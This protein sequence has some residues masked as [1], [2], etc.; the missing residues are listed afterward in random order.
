MPIRLRLVVLFTLAAALAFALG[1]WLF[2]EQLQRGLLGSLDASIAAQWT[3]AAQGLG[4]AHG[5]ENFQD[6]GGRPAG[7]SSSAPTSIIPPATEYVVQLL[8]PSG[9]V[10]ESN[11][12]AGTAPLLDRAQLHSATQR[13]LVTSVRGPEGDPFRLLAAPTAPGARQVVVVGASLDTVNQ[14][15]V[16]VRRD[17]LIGG[18]VILLASLLGAF[19]LATA[20]LLPVERLRRQVEDLS[21]MDK[22]VSV[23]VPNTKDEIA[24]LARTMNALLARLHHALVRQRSFVSDAGHELRTPFAILQ[25]ELELAGRSGR[26][27]EELVEAV[28]SAAEETARLTRLAEDLLFLARS[29][30]E[31]APLQITRTSLRSIL[32]R[33]AELVESRSENAGVR[34]LVEASDD[35]EADVDAGRI[36]QALDNLLDN[37]LRYA[38]RGSEIVVNAARTNGARSGRAR[39]EVGDRGPGFPSSFLPH[40]FE[41]FR[42]PD[43]GRARGDGGSGLGLA[44]VAAIAEGHGGSASVANREGG[45]AVATIELPLDTKEI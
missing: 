20:A 8:G 24:A 37:A 36:R 45:G 40:A 39:I 31:A 19:V 7:V 11:Q 32:E 42:R 1:G 13:A 10:L 30:E 17:L 25:A 33:S 29:D 2:A 21:A 35:L 5:Q 44:I 27:R 14:S 41:R 26:T 6:G 23:E 3:Q 4:S 28:N 34:V 43:D 38:P 18:I 15:A 16:T 12:A 22:D 9:R